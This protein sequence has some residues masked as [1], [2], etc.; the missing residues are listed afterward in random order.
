M[1]RLE[2]KWSLLTLHFLRCSTSIIWLKLL[3]LLFCII[4]PL[5]SNFSRL[6]ILCSLRYPL[7][8]FN[9]ILFFMFNARL[10]FFLLRFKMILL[11]TLPFLAI[12]LVCAF[13]RVVQSS[14]YNF[15]LCHWCAYHHLAN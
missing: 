11:I 14:L 4:I 15:A 1:L 13:S 5:M 7:K 2:S 8:A 10:P 3:L 9:S 6:L 12:V